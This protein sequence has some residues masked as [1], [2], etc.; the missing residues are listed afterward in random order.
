M[1]QL[2]GD[3]TVQEFG[4]LHIMF[5]FTIQ[6]LKEPSFCCIENFSFQ[7]ATE[8]LCDDQLWNAFIIRVLLIMLRNLPATSRSNSLLAPETSISAN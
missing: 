5:L 1:A 7:F 2:Y 6:A 8:D 4:H 3:P